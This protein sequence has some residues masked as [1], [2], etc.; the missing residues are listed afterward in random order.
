VSSCIFFIQ[1]N[2]LLFLFAFLGVTLFLLYLLHFNYTINSQRQKY[3]SRRG[4]RYHWEKPG[5]RY[6]KTNVI[7][8]LHGKRHV[9]VK[10]YTHSTKADFFN[11]W[12][13][14]ELLAAIPRFSL[15][16]MDNA[17]FHKKE[18]LYRIAAKYD[19]FLL[20]LPPYSPDFNPIEHSWANLKFWLIDNA[21]RFPSI[22]IAIEHYFHVYR[23]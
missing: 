23:Y 21:H 19:V 17:S 6:A 18:Q 5:R 12:F 3:R 16:I 14:W 7:A 15:V 4:I 20:F 8:G 11:D 2:T 9:A 10:C 13:E 22:D 1:F